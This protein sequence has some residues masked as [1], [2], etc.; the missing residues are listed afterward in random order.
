MA[1]GNQETEI[2]LAVANAQTARRL[3]RAAGFR[4]FR[5]RIFEANLVFDTPNLTLRRNRTLLRVREAGGHATFT[6]KGVPLAGRHK[7]REELEMEIPSARTLTQILERLGFEPKFRY[8]KFRSEYRAAG[9][10]GV[11]TLDETPIGVFMELEGGARWIDQ[12]ARKLGFAES[13]Y[14]TLSYSAL[15]L[16]WCKEH[17]VTPTHMVFDKRRKKTTP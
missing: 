3:L 1:H 14:I 15:Y 4:V 17:N 12:M 10:S 13:A 7:S 8:E 6:F 16:A 9:G 5:R 11:A 2:K